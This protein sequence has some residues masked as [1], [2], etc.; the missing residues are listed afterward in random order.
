[1]V[2]GL[3]GRAWSRYSGRKR[4][5]GIVLDFLFLAAL[6]VAAVPPLRRGGVTYTVRATLTQPSLYDKILFL[7]PDDE[8]RFGTGE[9][10]DTLMRFPPS[11]PTLL[12]VGSVWSS[13]TRAGLSSVSQSAEKFGERLDIFFLTSDSKDDVERY[14]RN[15]GYAPS[16]RPLYFS[17]EY[18]VAANADGGFVGQLLMSVPSSAL[19]GAD[20][21]VVVKK[22]GA[23]KWFGATADEAFAEAEGRSA[24]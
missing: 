23:T 16:I 21:R 12:V 6:V 24:E 4:R 17:E 22:L 9:G 20:G 2:E 8:L 18:A 14:F 7:G 11:R 5:R 15:R 13:Q 10:E 19:I 3:W 1:M